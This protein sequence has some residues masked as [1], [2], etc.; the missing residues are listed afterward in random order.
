MFFHLCGLWFLS[1]IFLQFQSR[2]ATLFKNYFE[3]FLFY[4]IVNVFLICFLDCSSLV[5]SLNTVD[6]YIL[7]FYPETLIN[8]FI[9]YNN[10]LVDPVSF[11]HQRLCHLKTEIILLPFHN[12]DAF[13]FFSSPNC[14][15]WDLYYNE[16]K[17]CGEQPCLVSYLRGNF[18]SFT[19]R[20]EVCQ[21][22]G[23]DRCPLTG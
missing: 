10:F 2:F 11:L 16:Q 18:Q 20:Y 6:F 9:S 7:I 3:A 4:A 13:R 23:F 1:I 17:Q 5:H 8:S 12:L 21:L 15:G 14:P 22:W 19:I